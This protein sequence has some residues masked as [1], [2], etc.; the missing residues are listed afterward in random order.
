MTWPKGRTSPDNF[1]SKDSAPQILLIEDDPQ[2]RRFLRTTLGAEGYRLHEARTAADGLQQAEARPPD[3][4]LL[5]LELPDSDGVEV[6]REIRQWNRNVPII[7]VSVRGRERD[8]ISTLDEGADDY[9]SKP[10]A[11]GELLARLRVALRRSA[12]A[13]QVAA[14][15]CFT[16]G[17]VDVDLERRRV[18]VSGA[19]VRLTRIEYRL[20]QILIQ[21]ADRVVTGRQLLN[22]VWGPKHT[23]QS[24]YLRIYMAQLRRKLEVDSSRPRFLKTE[25]GVGYRLT[26]E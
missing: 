7:V 10:F 26:T 15:S 18:L 4:I 11:I 16:F 25:P 6:I 20:L 9:V 14:S 8:K 19:E 5:D 23:G 2:I 22:E 1:V 17:R 12:A 24:H 13:P 3:V 21:H